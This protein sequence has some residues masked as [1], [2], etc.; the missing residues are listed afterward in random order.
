MEAT[1]VK[2]EARGNGSIRLNVV[3]SNMSVV[4]SPACW[5]NLHIRLEGINCN[6]VDSGHASPPREE[7]FGSDDAGGSCGRNRKRNEWW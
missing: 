1:G 5:R 6:E 7:L 2:S 3:A 4:Q